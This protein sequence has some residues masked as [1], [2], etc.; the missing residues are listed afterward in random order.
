[1]KPTD[2]NFKI[3]EYLK[4]EETNIKILITNYYSADLPQNVFNEKNNLV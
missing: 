4:Q 3:D 2:E 1:M